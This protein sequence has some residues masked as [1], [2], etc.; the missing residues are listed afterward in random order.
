[1][2]SVMLGQHVESVSVIL[3]LCMKPVVHH[4]KVS[5]FSFLFYWANFDDSGQLAADA[6]AGQTCSDRASRGKCDDVR[7][8][9]PGA[10]DAD[11]EAGR[12]QRVGTASLQCN[13]ETGV[14]VWESA[15]VSASS[16]P[17]SAPRLDDTRVALEVLGAITLAAIFAGC[18]HC[19]CEWSERRRIRRASIAALE[20]EILS[21]TE[22]LISAVKT[23]ARE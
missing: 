19:C 12:R 20:E 4:A 3:D 10:G 21:K 9:C 22:R 23:P 7:R 11:A 6:P 17:P 15:C 14:L 2:I 5:A 1:M 18:V 8:L 13:A 16:R